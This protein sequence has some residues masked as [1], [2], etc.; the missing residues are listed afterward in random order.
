MTKTT[1]IDYGTVKE[2]I[3]SFHL[4][5]FKKATIREI[6]AITNQVEE[7]TGDKFVR[8]EMGVPGLPP[9]KIGVDAEIEALKNGVAS[10]YP[11]LDGLAILKKEASRFVKAFIDID[12]APKGC[13]P[14]SGS[15]QGTFASFT[16]SS[17][18]D[19]K[20]DTVLFI[21]PGFP[22]QKSQLTV[23]G[24]KYVSFDMYDYWC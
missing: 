3:D 12:V 15:M 2:V 20:R 24:M 4:P 1:P 10:I 8:M 23:L 21:D 16:V 18:C 17:Q 19:P 9:E 7:K 5:D 13:V 22:V 11:M 6:V 14:V